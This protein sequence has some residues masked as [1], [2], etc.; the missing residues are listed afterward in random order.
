MLKRLAAAPVAMVH[1]SRRLD[2]KQR[3]QVCSG[4]E[5]QVQE[6]QLLIRKAE[7]LDFAEDA[8]VPS[9]T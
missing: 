4:H 8:I 6:N 7:C 2:I 1:P 5:I 9:H 3:R